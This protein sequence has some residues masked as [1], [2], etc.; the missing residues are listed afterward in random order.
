M[1]ISKPFIDRPIA[2]SLLMV[3]IFFSGLLS[4]FFIPIASLP[5]V[6]FPTI[7]VSTNYPG[8]SAKVM[9]STVTAVLER[10]LA[11]MPGLEQMSST[12]SQGLSLITLRFGLDFKLDIAQQQVQAAI[13]NCM[14]YLPKA[15]PRP[16][17]Y[18]KINPADAPIITLALTSN[19]I[20]LAKIADFAETQLVQKL[21]QISGIGLVTLSG[22][23]KESIKIQ[24]NTKQLAAYSL[25]TSDIRNAITNANVNTPKGSFNGLS[26]AYTINA[27]DQLLR[28]QDYAELVI[29]HPIRLMDVA[30][31]TRDV[32]NNQQA[33]FFNH[34]PAIIINIQ[35]QANANVIKVV[36]EIKE[37]LPTLSNNMPKEIELNIFHDATKMIRSSVKYVALELLGSIILVIM[38][39]FVFLRKISTT[40]IPSLVLPLSLV[41]SLGV[42]YLLGFS[43]N[44]L[45]LMALIVATGFVVDDA[46]VMIENISRYLEMGEGPLN[47]AYRG[48]KEI[49]FTI[50]SLTIS[51]LAV[52]IPL[53]FMEDIVGKLFREFA[54]TLACSIII[55][56]VISLTLTPML[57]AKILSAS[58]IKNKFMLMLEQA[59]ESLKNKYSHSLSLVLQHQTITMYIVITTM[60]I[61]L[62]LFIKMPTGFFPEQYNGVLRGAAIFA[63]E[64]SF[65]QISKKQQKLSEIILQDKDVASVIFLLGI[66]NNN[67]TLNNVH[68]MIVLKNQQ[69]NAHEVMLRLK[70]ASFTELYL[71][72][73][74]DI[75]IDDNLTPSKYQ[76]SISSYDDEATILATRAILA[77]MKQ[78]KYLI[79]VISNQ[80]Q[81]GLSLNLAI[82]RQQAATLGV[83][84]QNIVDALYDMYG[85]RQISTIFT[86]RNQHNVVLEALPHLL[87]GKKSLDN[88][89]VKSANAKIVELKAFTKISEQ[90]TPML[91]TRENQFASAT[92]SFD[93]ATGVSLGQAI[94]SINELKAD[95]PTHIQSNFQGIAKAFT[96]AK[97]NEFWLIIAAVL[98]VY[99]VLGMLYESY[100]HPLTI[101]STLPSACIGALL[102][103]TLFNKDLDVIAMIGIILLIGI[104]KKNAIMMIDF[105]LDAQRVHHKSPQD[106]IFQACILRFRPILMT[107]LASFF[108]AL[109]LAFDQSSQIRQTL[110]ISIIGGILISQVFTLY[111][112]PVIYLFFEKLGQSKGTIK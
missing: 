34:K 23:S 101:I 68:M 69:I 30:N 67:R 105:A 4:Y 27:N 95:L 59:L 15:L 46:I 85:Q 39:M 90:K 41:G 107:S 79:N 86:Q 25:T 6:D 45:T 62:L 109:P 64:S 2:T 74:Q 3:A 32:E 84:M 94:K 88:V 61:C 104:V 33:A 12:S 106:A 1:Q 40:I 98:V 19:S 83:N 92:I 13:S 87:L 7:V 102:G 77:K 43:I 5:Q 49:A 44:N 42:I 89:Y 71:Q 47:A 31:I 53:F 55:S 70:K 52:L 37:L 8:A 66:D 100:I 10:S 111:T 75:T 17:I 9:A 50:F 14:Y 63:P 72:P 76:L 16:P 36:D 20:S 73:L 110:G 35:K 97:G 80:P 60:G 56:A 24:V 21:S 96:K 58:P 18:S 29:A 103:L 112:T 99:I 82:N 54:L 65:A 28:S 93:L 108:A 48:A 81:N 11:Q 26:V 51:L 22:A 78:N 91:I 57:C 38:V